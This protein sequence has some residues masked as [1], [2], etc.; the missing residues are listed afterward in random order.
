MHPRDRAEEKR[1]NLKDNGPKSE[2]E[3][4]EQQIDSIASSAETIAKPG[5]VWRLGEHVLVCGDSTDPKTFDLLLGADIA[6]MTWTDPPYNIGNKSR[7]NDLVDSG[8]ESIQNDK[9]DDASWAA[10]VRGWMRSH[11]EPLM[12]GRKMHCADSEPILYGWP[13]GAD[14]NGMAAGMN[15]TRG[16]SSVPARTR[17]IRRKSRSSWSR[18]RSRTRATAATRCSTRS[19]AGEAR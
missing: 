16:F 18:R 5:D 15:R 6:D 1:W 10:F 19:P 14:H 8:S 7:G 11:H 17:C 9:M 4:E 12:V 3:C 13:K 2:P